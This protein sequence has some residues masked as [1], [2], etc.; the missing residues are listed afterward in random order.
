MFYRARYYDPKIGRFISEDPIGFEGEDINLYRYV[1]NIPVVFLD[2]SGEMAIIGTGLRLVR[3]GAGAAI[4]L[5]KR[6]LDI[7]NFFVRN[8]SKHQLAL[9]AATLTPFINGS[10]KGDSMCMMASDGAVGAG[11]YWAGTAAFARG[12]GLGGSAVVAGVVGYGLAA[13]F[14]QIVCKVTFATQIM[15]PPP[16]GDYPPPTGNP[17]A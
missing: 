1:Y 2:P 14:S 13:L 9:G 8:L 12:A 10:V 7:L 5:L 11:A 6:E 15:P 4:K 17:V 16:L 3:Q